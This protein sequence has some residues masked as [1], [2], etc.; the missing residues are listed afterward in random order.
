MDFKKIA[1][2]IKEEND[3]MYH[4]IPFTNGK[5]DRTSGGDGMFK[6]LN[7]AIWDT[8]STKEDWDYISEKYNWKA[9]ELRVV[10]QGKVLKVIRL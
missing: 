8:E 9:D 5:E 3:R 1:K 10:Y 4:V 7:E 6:T 2:Q